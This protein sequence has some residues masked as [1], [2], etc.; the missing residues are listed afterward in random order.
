VILHPGVTGVVLAGGRA[1][2]LGGADKA[3]LRP[4]NDPR[5]ILARIL[6]VFEG[7]FAGTVI[8]AA[9]EEAGRSR[10]AGLPA[11]VVADDFP[12]CGPLGGLHAGLGAVATPFAFVCACDMP[13][14]CPPLIDF[15]ARRARADTAVVPVR[16][17]RPEPL[18]A[19]YPA[20]WRAA[21]GRA[22]ERGVRTMR[23]FLDGLP[24]DWLDEEAQGLVEGSARSF[25]NVN[26]PEDLEAL[27]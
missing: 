12:G 27:S 24:V 5:T 8:V 17:G 21:A 22:L 19:I 7:R 25:T 14:L 11:R 16:Q 10:Y 9:T 1:R 20:A 18:H 2:R 3:M 15:M 6:E 26:T 23:D 13:S 4:G